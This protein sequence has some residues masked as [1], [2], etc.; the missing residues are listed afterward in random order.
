MKNVFD[1]CTKQITVFARFALLFLILEN[2]G[3]L[4]QSNCVAPPSGLAAWWQAEGTAR[5]VAGGINGVL[6]NGTTFGG[7][8]VGQA[9]SFNGTNQYITNSPPGLTN[10]V[11]SYTIEFWARPT[12]ARAT[13]AESTGNIDGTANQRYAIFPNNGKFGAAGS[14]VSVGTNGVSVFESG[15]AY[16]RALLVYDTPITNWTHI[17]VVY[18]NQQPS[19]YLN[20]ALVHAGLTSTRSSYPSTC[21]GEQGVGYGYYA[22]LL[23]EVSIYNRPLTAAE[24]A[25]IYNASSA[26]KCPPPTPPYIVIQPTNETVTAGST[27][28]FSVTAGGSLPL[29]YQW[30]F[31]GGTI[32]NATNSS[33]ILP[34]VQFSEAGLYSVQVTNTLG[35]TNSIQALL[36]VI[37]ATPPCAP[38]PADIIGWW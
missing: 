9:F 7:G 11:N 17:T 10:V 33:L 13:T 35:S 19:L 20:G 21:L 24:L 6:V 27:V 36:T 31:N 34:N 12:M 5:N 1:F 23:D 37:S 25:A 26:G 14:G 38:L 18:S 15:S 4:A 29:S 32:A 30:S 16:L 28:I 22:G 3:A 2:L 8:Y